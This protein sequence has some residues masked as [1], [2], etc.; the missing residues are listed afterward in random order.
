MLNVIV[1]TREQRPWAFSPDAIQV[2]RGTLSTGDYALDGDAHFA[3]ERKSLG[4]FLG[5]IGTGWPRFVREVKRMQDFVARVIIVEADYEMLCFRRDAQG[6]LLAPDHEFS[7]LT[8]GFVQ[9]RIA[10][11]TLRGVSVLFARNAELAAGLATECLKV[12]DQQR[13]PHSTDAAV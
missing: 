2:T 11:L 10:E 13:Q 9:R 3:I 5:T 7:K 4:D 12:R 8:P 1:D 6:N